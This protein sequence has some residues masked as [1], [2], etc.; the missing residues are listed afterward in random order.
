M[1]S[2]AVLAVLAS[3]LT[4]RCTYG[5]GGPSSQVLATILADE[6]SATGR[7]AH[8][9]AGNLDTGRRTGMT[10]ESLR[11]DGGTVITPEGPRD[12]QVLVADGRV[13]ALRPRDEPDVAPSW[14]ASGLIVAPGFIDLQV[15]GGHG[16]DLTADLD[17]HPER[18]WQLAE[19]LPG[20]GVTAFVPTVVSSPPGSIA[21]ALLASRLRPTDHLG[22]E[23]LG[24]HAE[25]PMLAPAKRGTHDPLQ[26]R[27]PDPSVVATWSRADGVAMATIAP[28]LPG[29]LEVIR[30]LVHRDVVV[31]LGHTEAS[32]E[33]AIAALDAG[34]RAGTHLFNAMSGWSAREP[35]VVGAL[36]EDPR[37]IV[38]MIVDEVHLHPAT[39]A[40]AWRLLG[41]ER[42]AL[43]TDAIA[44]AGLGDGAA[45]LGGRRL[46]VQDGVVRDEDGALAGSVVTLD[47]ALR[48]LV[49]ATGVD[50]STALRAVTSTPASL[51]GE[52]ERGRLAPGARAD[53][54]VLTQ[55]LE[56]VATFVAGKLAA[57]P[58]PDLLPLPTSA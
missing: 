20:Q 53:L 29:A 22:A 5:P 57:H 13:A 6:R 32:Y 4:V 48:N 8:P 34:A 46:T 7:L 31:S 9:E 30:T 24:V 28:E 17:D 45:S 3:V 52:R 36:L 19:H 1:W 23:P 27:D 44:A 14:D 50:P 35:G 41:P 18:L 55:N 21:A 26:L 12:L 47:R 56:V 49:A 37:A 54:V 33:Q 15:N 10:G 38:G 42:V 16:I 39:V 43:V 25:G 40:A 51:L 58:R 2:P 11:I